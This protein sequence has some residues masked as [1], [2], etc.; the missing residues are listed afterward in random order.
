VGGQPQTVD[1]SDPNNVQL[2]SS[3]LFDAY[4]RVPDGPGKLS[5][6]P[7]LTRNLGSTFT[8]AELQQNANTK[9]LSTRSM[10]IFTEALNGLSSGRIPTAQS[11]DQRS[12]D[13]AS[14]VTF[15]PL[16]AAATDQSKAAS[17]N[18]LDQV[19]DSLAQANLLNT[20][21]GQRALAETQLAGNQ[22]SARI[23]PQ[24]A[25]DFIFQLAPGAAFGTLP[26]TVSGLSG[27]AGAQAQTAGALANANQNSGFNQFGSF[28]GQALGSAGTTY[29][30][31]T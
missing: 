8:L 29:A 1:L 17:S 5:D 28:L 14:G 27:A 23:G 21:F 26:T 24:L 30:L 10:R 4:R 22:Q 12:A 11:L 6:I 19:R 15:S 16:I 18:T 2:T 13:A 3:D 20:P 25:S 9:G 7:R 31:S